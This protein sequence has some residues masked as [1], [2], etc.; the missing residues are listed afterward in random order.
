[1]QLPHGGPISIHC[2]TNCS[3][4]SAGSDGCRRGG[5]FSSLFCARHARRR[6][7]SETLHWVPRLI[8]STSARTAADELAVAYQRRTLAA[9]A[10]IASTHLAGTN[11]RRVRRALAALFGGT[12]GISAGSAGLSFCAISNSLPSV[13]LSVVLI[14][15]LGAY[16]G[17][18]AHE[19]PRVATGGW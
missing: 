14:F 4:C 1:M 15:I 2:A 10:L 7:E 12:V 13:D 5:I 19:W 11:T 6:A 3:N 18:G 16:S 17:R 9:D 8:L